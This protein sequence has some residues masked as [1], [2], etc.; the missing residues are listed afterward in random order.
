MFLVF[1][2]ENLRPKFFFFKHLLLHVCVYMKINNQVLLNLFYFKDRYAS[3]LL[4][5]DLGFFKF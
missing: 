1:H 4:Y 3:K 2:V 5:W